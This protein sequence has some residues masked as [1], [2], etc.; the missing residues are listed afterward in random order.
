MNRKVP[1]KVYF[2]V[3]VGFF[4]CLLIVW[5]FSFRLLFEIILRISSPLLGA[6]ISFG[7]S[8]AICLL[9]IRRSIEKEMLAVDEPFSIVAIDPSVH[10]QKEKYTVKVVFIRLL[11]AIIIFILASLPLTKIGIIQIIC[12]KSNT[13]DL[14]VCF[15]DNHFYFYIFCIDSLYLCSICNIAV[16]KKMELDQ[17]SILRYKSIISE[18]YNHSVKPTAGKHGLRCKVLCGGGLP[19]S[20][21][22]TAPRSV[23]SGR[24]VVPNAMDRLCAP[25]SAYP[26]R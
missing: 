2:R 26:W 12:S 13:F 10:I 4:F 22:R 21:G 20:I 1:L 17:T 3:A 25:R 15:I 23:L 18:H 9:L 24:A 14:I 5:Y 7:I 6:E 11:A 19:K 16:V 8:F